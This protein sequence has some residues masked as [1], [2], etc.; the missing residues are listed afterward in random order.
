MSRAQ[1]MTLYATVLTHCTIISY[2]HVFDV[3][4]TH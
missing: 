3:N 2:H 1:K 4:M